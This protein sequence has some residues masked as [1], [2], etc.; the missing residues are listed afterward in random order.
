MR[1]FKS[2]GKKLTSCISCFGRGT[3]ILEDCEDLGIC[4]NCN[5]VSS[6]ISRIL[7][8]YGTTY[9]EFHNYDK[10]ENLFK[11]LVD[12]SK[13][14]LYGKKGQKALAY[15]K[16][17]RCVDEAYLDFY[18][19]GY[20]PPYFKY[21]KYEEL[22]Q[23]LKYSTPYG[24]FFGG[25]IVFPIRSYH[26]GN[27]VG[28]ASRHPEKKVFRHNPTNLLYNKKNV[29]Y[30]FYD[31]LETIQ[32]HKQLV[33]VESILDAISFQQLYKDSLKYRNFVPITTL[34]CSLPKSGFVEYLHQEIS[35]DQVVLGYDND[36]IGK[37][38]QKRMLELLRQHPSIVEIT[39]Y[40]RKYAS[41]KDISEEL[42]KARME[43]KK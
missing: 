30:G 40:R 39:K 3:V 15:L 8:Y 22:V 11:D 5:D 34:S 25:Q 37:D 1:V 27:V 32:K 14:F 16:N 21:D 13:D 18:N 35:V 24:F 10:Y 2:G 12:V 42:Q 38:A 36:E 6:A 17:V 41:C 26:F 19:V 33:I 7:D 28:F 4:L 9:E 31:N 20:F 23:E 29:V 43:G